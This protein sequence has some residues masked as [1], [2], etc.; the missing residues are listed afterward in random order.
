LP[1]RIS[2][3]GASPGK[4]RAKAIVFR[5]ADPRQINKN[6]KEGAVLI[7]PYSSPL[8]MFA[9]L[10]AGAI[11]TD[12]GGLSCHAAILAREIGTPC[13]VNTRVATTRIDTGSTVFVDGAKG[14]VC[15]FKGPHRPQF[16]LR[17][18]PSAPR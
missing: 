7:I 9:L 2:G 11:V 17:P 18:D 6:M 14:L 10:K 8:I 4:A 5:K 12:T 3:I 13:V 1:L 16:R 15:A